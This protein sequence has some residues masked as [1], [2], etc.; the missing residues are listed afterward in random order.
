MVRKCGEERSRVSSPPERGLQLGGRVETDGR[1]WSDDGVLEHHLDRVR[2]AIVGAVKKGRNST[3]LQCGPRLT[4][5][6]G[7]PEQSTEWH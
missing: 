3:V 1:P 2:A 7:K 4:M 6:E 5:V